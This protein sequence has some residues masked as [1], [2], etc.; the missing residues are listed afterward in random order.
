MPRF[1]VS[2]SI[3]DKIALRSITERHIEQCFANR[4]GEFLVDEREDHKS[5]PATLWFISETNDGTPLKIAFIPRGNDFYIRSAFPANEKQT[6][7]Y[8]DLG[9]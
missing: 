3:R 8:N 5:D 4:C 1:I 6:R 9:K 7:I 2:P